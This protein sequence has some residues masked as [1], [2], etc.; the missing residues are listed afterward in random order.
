MIHYPDTCREP[1]PAARGHPRAYRGGE[2]EPRARPPVPAPHRALRPARPPGRH[3]RHRRPRPAGRLQTLLRELKLYDPALLKKPRLVV[4]NKMDLPAARP[5]WRGSGA[6]IGP[7][8]SEVSCVTGTGLAELKKELLK[9]VLPCAPEKKSRLCRA[10]ENPRHHVG[11][12][13]IAHARQ[14]PARRRPGR[15]QPGQDRGSRRR[16]TSGC[17][18]CC[19]TTPSDRR[20]CWAC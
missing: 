18:S 1:P 13:D 11:A 7:D 20:R 3:G 9:R 19:R 16:P 10:A 8:F 12:P 6:A 4:A 5:T 14:P 2:R 17:S 15:G